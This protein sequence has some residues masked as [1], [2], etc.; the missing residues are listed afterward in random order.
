[1]HLVMLL[2][3]YLL[4]H[5][6]VSTPW[7]RL[8]KHPR[9]CFSMTSPRENIRPQSGHD[10]LT[11]KWHASTWSRVEVVYCSPSTRT[12]FLGCQPRGIGDLP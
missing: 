1:M 11:C 4:T 10:A 3:I 8:V 6:V 7:G 2:G 5:E 12:S 9:A